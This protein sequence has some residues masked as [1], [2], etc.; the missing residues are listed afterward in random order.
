[1]N[2]ILQKLIN[3]GIDS[4]KYE[5]PSNQRPLDAEV[6][7]NIYEFQKS[8]YIINN[9][10]C[11]NGTISI[12]KDESISEEFLLDGQH[13]MAAF[14]KL[15]KEFPEREMT[16]NVDYFIVKNEEMRNYVYKYINTNTPHLIT[17][18]TIDKYK[19]GNDFHKLMV[20]NF[21]QYI[22]T[23]AKPRKPHI[24]IEQVILYLNEIEFFNKTNIKDGQELY[25]HVINL[26]KFYSENIEK[27]YKEWNIENFQDTLDKIN[28]KENVLY[29]GIYDKFE[30]VDRIVDKINGTEYRDMSHHQYNFQKREKITSSLRESVWRKTNSNSLDGSCYVCNKPIS[31][32]NFDCGHIIASCKGGKEDI[33][34]LVA[35]C[36]RCNSDMGTMNLND[37]KVIIERQMKK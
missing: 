19:I 1:M 29:L 15:R 2:F 30:W 11:L 34:N 18:L 9:S 5:I 28:E 23:S 4:I 10:Y 3:Q 35:T 27:K 24:N 6:L 13:R 16:V 37:Y 26:N 17:K 20:K 12:C 36:K 7:N 33:D 14:K 21:K 32:Y 31:I 22:K 8:Y 25:L